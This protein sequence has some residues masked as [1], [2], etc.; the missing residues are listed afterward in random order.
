MVEPPTGEVTL[1]FT[2][3]E[4]S[5]SLLQRSGELYADLLAHHRRILRAAVVAQ[6]GYEVDTEGDAFFFAFHSASGAVLAAA[7]AQR[8]LARH[9]WPAGHEV[10][11]RMGAH[12]GEPRL[13]DRAYVGLDVHRAARVMAAG[14][15]G[16]VL[17]SRSTRKQLGDDVP[18]LDLGEHRLKDLLQPE[19]LFQLV[20]EGLPA[21]FPALKTLGNH[22][23]NLPLQPNALIGREVEVREICGLLRTDDARLLTLT[24]PGGAGKTRLALQ[25]GAELL[26][27]FR[28]GVFFVSL[29]PLADG[30]LLLSTI[31]ETLAIR[32][33]AGVNLADTLSAYLSDKQMLLVLDNFEQIIDAAPSVAALLGAAPDIQV[34]VTSRERLRVSGEGVY[35]VPPL[36]LPDAGPRDLDGLLGSDAIALFV[37][38]S[39]TAAP[40]FRLTHANAA[41]V[42]EICRQLDGLPLALELAAART[43]VLSPA[44]LLGRLDDRLHILTGGTRDTHE[45]HRTLRDTIAWSYDLLSTSDQLLF[46][47]LAVFAD[48]CRL[49]AAEAVWDAESPKAS[50]LDG[51]QSL[52]D[53]SLV[54]HRIDPDGEVRF[55]MLETIREYAAEQ[56][57]QSREAETA[58]RLH[59][60]HFL[61]L[62]E[63][64]EPELWAQQTD[65]WIPRL[66]VE[67][68]NFRA[69]LEWAL[70]EGSPVVGLRLAGSLYPFWEIRAQQREART[71][72]DRALALN[73]EAP[74]A[75]RA[76]ALAAA[77]RAAGWQFQWRDVIDLL[78]EA[79]S[80]YRALGDLEGVGRCLGFVGHAL[81]FT[82]DNDRA[83][84]VLDEGIELARRTGHG[85]SV[86][87]ALHNAAFLAIEER[88]FERA[89][90]MFE[91]AA[92]VSRAE[93]MN[94]S[95]A[96]CLSHLGLAEALSGDHEA[97]AAHL[98]E[99][100]ALF[101][102]VGE[103]PWTQM[104]VR[105]Q[106]L[107]ALLEGEIDEAESLLRAGLAK[108]REQTL[109]Q[110][111][112]SWIDGLAAVADANGEARRAAA[113]WGAAD[114]VRQDL[115][116]VVLEESRQIRERFKRVPDGTPDA[117]SWKE[118]WARGHAMTLEQAIA[119]ALA[120]ETGP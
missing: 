21:Q 77:G 58:A 48:G 110:E 60:E 44:A 29:A 106:G 8:T 20:I 104:A 3:I 11:V 54:R 18:V 33:V 86:A 68:A 98:E 43:G 67:Q 74:P 73:G 42:V 103:T 69:A 96:M 23:T 119:L 57:L 64:A 95:L 24:G 88:D 36:A 82:G 13:V 41:A 99:G 112:P 61:E 7:E 71:W 19:H 47:R 120:D 80:C 6:E 35:E 16:Q 37:A 63:K 83:R 107:S 31:A 109:R 51:L 93:R 55:W 87:R 34:L 27:A 49:D 78:E 94:L 116:L 92:R 39:E 15:G 76:K 114:A 118:A 100:V 59:A 40:A 79:V 70:S 115:G 28:S 4:G 30:S 26:E 101:A 25:V 56:A 102:E 12:T 10:R 72:L 108:G 2:D 90:Q 9:S 14:H 81:L 66:E 84:S 113:L 38:R 62:A 22:P 89:C 75:S 91:E 105:Y 97:A 1:L 45:R 111:V 52:V 65:V 53:K 117:D 5:T 85:Q 17:L 50:V 46:R 32:E